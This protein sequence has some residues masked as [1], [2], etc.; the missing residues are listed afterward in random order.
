MEPGPNRVIHF[1]TYKISSVWSY[2]EE[3]NPAEFYSVE[4]VGT[5]QSVSA[6]NWNLTTG[7]KGGLHNYLHL[8]V[9][10][11][12]FTDEI[13]GKKHQGYRPFVKK[14]NAGSTVSR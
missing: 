3:R 9:T 8:F 2:K 7:F 1:F 4:G 10:P 6:D 11:T 12:E 5:P 13:T 14:F